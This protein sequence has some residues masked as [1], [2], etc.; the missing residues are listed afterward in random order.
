MNE[1]FELSLM[2]KK[3]TLEIIIQQPE[4]SAL[5]NEISTTTSLVTAMVK[6]RLK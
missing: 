4:L 2:L 6:D 5:S 3:Q 1:I